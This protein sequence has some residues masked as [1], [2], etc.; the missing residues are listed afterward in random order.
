MQI[1]TSKD[2]KTALVF[3]NVSED[4]SDE[5]LQEIKDNINLKSLYSINL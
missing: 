1:A 5:V 4:V 2:E 3:V